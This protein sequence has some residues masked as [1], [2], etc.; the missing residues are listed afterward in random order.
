MK[1]STVAI[2]ILLFFSC[3]DKEQRKID[4]SKTYNRLYTPI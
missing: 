4:F 1:N 3:A 2:L